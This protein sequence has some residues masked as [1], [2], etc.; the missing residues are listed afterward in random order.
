MAA[1]NTGKGAKY[2]K[3][4]RPVELVY[5]E[6]F[7]HIDQAIAREKILK[8]WRRDRKD[9]LITSFNPEWNDLSEGW[10]K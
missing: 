2:T 8:G 10:E 7:N 9:A 6:E 5:F 1:H 3:A 4:R